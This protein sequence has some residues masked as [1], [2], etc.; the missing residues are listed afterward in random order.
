[1]LI[2]PATDLRPDVEYASAKEAE[3]GYL[4]PRAVLE[5]SVVLYLGKDGDPTDPYVSPLLA[6]TLAGLPPALVMTC[7]YDPVRDAGEAYARA[8]REAGVPTTSRR[9]SGFVHNAH[10]YTALLPEAR[11]FRAAV[12][13]F[14]KEHHA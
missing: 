6:E 10:V 11:D 13:D 7:E 14:L 12:V 3:S 2:V 8:L 1:V 4:M 5:E 9:W